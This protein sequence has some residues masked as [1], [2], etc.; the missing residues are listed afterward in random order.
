[1]DGKGKV[2]ATE[3]GKGTGMGQGMRNGKGKGIIN[4]TPEGDDISRAIDLQLWKDM[5]EA[6]LASES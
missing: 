4:W 2:K 3:D 1:M 6:D 5:S